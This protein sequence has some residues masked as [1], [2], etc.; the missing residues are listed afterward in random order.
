[1]EQQVRR[2]FRSSLGS[3]PATQTVWSWLGWSRTF[4]QICPRAVLL[5][6]VKG[7]EETVKTC[8]VLLTDLRG[9]LRLG[10][11]CIPDCK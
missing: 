6:E 5:E 7:T 3:V 8:R 9:S 4:L 10:S 11:L 1:M 2:A